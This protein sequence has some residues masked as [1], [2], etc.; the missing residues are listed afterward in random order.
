MDPPGGGLP[1]LSWQECQVGTLVGNAAPTAI[2]PAGRL[3]LLNVVVSASPIF[4]TLTLRKGG[5]VQLSVPSGMA[6][7]LDGRAF[8]YVLS[9]TTGP[10]WAIVP[11]DAELTFEGGV[12][13]A[14]TANPTVVSEAAVPPTSIPASTA[15]TTE[16][17]SSPTPNTGQLVRYSLT[18]E[19][20]LTFGTLSYIAIKGA[21]SGIYYAVA[22]S[23]TAISGTFRMGLSENLLLVA[24]N[25]SGANAMMVSGF[26]QTSTGE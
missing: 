9:N 7:S 3:D 5:T 20:G 24:R 4:L 25:A 19:A 23:G 8:A 12:P 26:L 22:S 15:E 14:A 17:T 1:N 21:T 11:Q 13:L 10:V 18:A 6:L 2:P 16:A